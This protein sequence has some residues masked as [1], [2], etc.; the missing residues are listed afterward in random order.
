MTDRAPVERVPGELFRVD[1]TGR[2]LLAVGG[3]DRRTFLQGLVSND[4]NKASVERAIHAAFLTPQGRFLNEFAIVEHGERLLLETEAAQLADLLKRLGMYRL[5]SKVTLEPAPDWAVVALIGDAAPAA[6]GL[7]AE[8]G[9]ATAFLDGVA[10]VDPRLAALG[11]RLLL[12]RAALPRLAVCGWAPAPVEVYERRRL[13][14][15]VPEGGIDLDHALLMEN[16]F[17]ALNGIDWKKGCYIGQ[18]VTARMRYRALTRRRI[19]PVRIDGPVPAPG[20]PVTLDGVEAGEMKSV[21]DD[22]GLALL[23][24]EQLERLQAAG[25]TLKAGEATLA[26]ERA[27]WLA[28]EAAVPDAPG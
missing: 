22:R 3:A 4:V 26:V 14:L 23:R 17:D 5:R 15:G 6:V 13:A 28:D 1:L 12:P 16:G 27:A 25:G 24:L 11:V 21:L 10:F 7:R 19:T 2:A 8:A 20:T 18:E 9:A